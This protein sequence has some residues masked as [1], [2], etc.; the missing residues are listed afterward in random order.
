MMWLVKSNLH[1]C[2]HMQMGFWEFL[3]DFLLPVVWNELNTQS[4]V[5]ELDNINSAY[6]MIVHSKIASH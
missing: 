4:T 5:K 3:K 1:M 6:I 2:K